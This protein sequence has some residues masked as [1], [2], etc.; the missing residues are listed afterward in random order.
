MPVIGVAGGSA[1][2]GRTIVEELLK[3]KDK[4]DVK[5]LARQA[6]TG[7]LISLE[8]GNNIENCQLNP[9]L[10]QAIGAPFVAVDYTDVKSLTKIL[11][12]NEIHTVISTLSF[13]A[14]P[15]T[16]I[17]EV[18]L[19][20]AAGA[21]GTTKRYVSN[22]WGVPIRDGEEELAKSIMAFKVNGL[23]ALKQSANLEYTS[24]YTGFFS[25][26][27]GYPVVKTYMRPA[28]LV[29]DIQNN[30]A[31]IPGA[32]NTRVGFAHT[33][34]VAK[35]V[36]A[37]MDL[38]KWEREYNLVV[39]N[40]TLN[41]FLALAENARGVKFD[42]TYDSVETLKSGKF[43]ELPAQSKSGLFGTAAGDAIRKHLAASLLTLDSGRFDF[44]DGV[45]G[46]DAFPEIKPMTVK[47]ILEEAWGRRFEKER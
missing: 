28:S 15:G 1:G 3:N 5:V 33:S 7:F 35:Y 18:E 13:K 32:G 43:T 41:E 36:T 37:A 46:R 42:V 9:E 22:N 25:D 38:E 31:V 17:P 20:T 30:A 34:D 27:W 21:S 23:A 39:D 45:R 47:D 6:C 40:I 2:I 11:E 26:Y 44:D 4:H 10:E 12:D 16:T 14:A 8:R 24:F 29:L 19:V